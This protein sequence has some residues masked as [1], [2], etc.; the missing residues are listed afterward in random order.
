MTISESP[1]AH[2]D[3]KAVLDRALANGRG[4][5]IACASI[6]EARNL[7]QRCYTFRKIDRKS[8]RDIYS[9]DDPRYG[10]SVY[11]QLSCYPA[12]EADGSPCCV[13]EVLSPDRLNERVQDL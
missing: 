4:V 8:N 10:V 13:I 6:G 5:K 7:V 3:I 11:D 12:E 9:L 1:L 2:A